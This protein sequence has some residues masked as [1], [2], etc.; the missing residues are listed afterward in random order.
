MVILNYSIYSIIKI[1]YF[2]AFLFYF[3]VSMINFYFL[4]SF[5]SNS[6][7]EM[8]SNRYFLNSYNF[9]IFKNCLKFFFL[10]YDTT[11]DT[12]SKFFK[13]FW[14]FCFKNYYTFFGT[15]RKCPFIFLYYYNNRIMW[16][17]VLQGT[18]F[19]Y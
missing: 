9:N 13:L 12:S 18:E 19:H 3:S 15:R 6:F 11:F 2:F 1:N 14:I 17:S 8:F 4:K 5:D 10:N 16:N 7:F